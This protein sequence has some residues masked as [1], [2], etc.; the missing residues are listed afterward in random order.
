MAGRSGH[1][2]SHRPWSVR[3]DDQ[4]PLTD[5]RTRHIVQQPQAR[6]VGVVSIV[7]DEYRTRAGRGKAQ[8]FGRANE[9]PL[10]TALSYPLR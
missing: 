9:Q 5:R 3:D 10:V 6:L 4:N 1:C 7:H 2:R 8:Q